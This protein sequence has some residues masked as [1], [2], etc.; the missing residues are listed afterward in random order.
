MTDRANLE[1]IKANA[2]VYKKRLKINEEDTQ[3]LQVEKARFSDIKNEFGQEMLAKAQERAQKM[4]AETSEPN[5]LDPP[6]HDEAQR[7]A[8]ELQNER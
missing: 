3:E 7:L 6:L 8:I 4:L 2:L 5:S 1:K